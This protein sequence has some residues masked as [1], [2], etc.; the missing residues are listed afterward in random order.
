M[1]NREQTP[2]EKLFPDIRWM[3]MTGAVAESNLTLNITFCSDIYWQWMS[4]GFGLASERGS[5]VSPRP[6][7]KKPQKTKQ[8]EEGGRGDEKTARSSSTE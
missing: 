7:K 1:N 3:E 5:D 2:N 6:K 4:G 8:T